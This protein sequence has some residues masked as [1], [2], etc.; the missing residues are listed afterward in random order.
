MKPSSSGV[1]EK[2]RVGVVDMGVYVTSHAALSKVDNLRV[3]FGRE[4]D[5]F[6]GHYRRFSGQS[7]SLN[8]VEIEPA[9]PAEVCC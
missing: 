1:R 5:E 8:V 9:P 7:A 6:G 2:L 4:P 3:A